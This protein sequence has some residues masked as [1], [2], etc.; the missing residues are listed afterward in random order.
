MRQLDVVAR[1]AQGIGDMQR[2]D[3]R[4]PLPR[5]QAVGDS[6]R[7]D[8]S[9]RLGR[10]RPRQRALQDFVHAQVS[11][12]DRQV[13]ADERRLGLAAR[14]QMRVDLHLSIAV[15]QHLETLRVDRN[16]ELSDA[17]LV[18]GETATDFQRPAAAVFQVKLSMTM[19]SGESVRFRRAFLY[20]TLVVV[21]IN[22]ASVTA[23]VPARC[24][25]LLM[26]TACASIR[27]S[28]SRCGR[29]PSAL[30]SGRD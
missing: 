19:R 3:E 9:G 5:I 6:G 10:V 11:G 14:L 25:S 24:G 8:K 12:S 18:R 22:E 20:A 7:F 4:Q 1:Q 16:F 2:E 30:R 15:P 23:T 26:P 28:P 17:Q 29:Y 13:A 21:T 27:I